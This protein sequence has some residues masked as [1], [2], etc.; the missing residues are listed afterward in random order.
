MIKKQRA[1]LSCRLDIRSAT[2]ARGGSRGRVA[3]RQAQA[4]RQIPPM[5]GREGE[6]RARGAI[7]VLGAIHVDGG[8]C[9]DYGVFPP[10]GGRGA[11]LSR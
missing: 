2:C 4:A 1:V 8:S 7:C 5:G 10:I 9:A 3:G 11:G 6:A